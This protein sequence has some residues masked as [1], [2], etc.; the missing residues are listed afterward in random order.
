M[1]QMICSL[2]PL[3]SLNLAVTVYKA[4]EACLIE[5]GQTLEPH[6]LNKKYET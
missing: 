6:C 4:R 1:V 5:R 3:S 2:F